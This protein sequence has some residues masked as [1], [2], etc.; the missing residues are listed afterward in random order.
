LAHKSEAILLD[1]RLVKE[2]HFVTQKLFHSGRL[3]YFP[4]EMNVLFC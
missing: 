3:E 2:Y 4:Y 1:L